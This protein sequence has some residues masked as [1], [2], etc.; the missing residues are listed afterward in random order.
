MIT[1][2]H[3]GK[4]NWVDRRQLKTLKIINTSAVLNQ[5]LEYDNCLFLAGEK[6]IKVDQK[7][8]ISAIKK[9]SHLATTPKSLY[10]TSD[11]KG[12]FC[13]SSTFN[14]QVPC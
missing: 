14:T 9:V 10:G 2:G 6:G 12:M 5:V 3:D 11:E 4:I 7:G 8:K 13:I 1:V